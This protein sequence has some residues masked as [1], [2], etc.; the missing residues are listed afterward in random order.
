MKIIF[1]INRNKLLWIFNI[2]NLFAKTI[3]IRTIVLLSGCYIS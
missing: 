1:R 3:G 2:I